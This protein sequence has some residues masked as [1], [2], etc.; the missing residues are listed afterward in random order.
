MSTAAFAQHHQHAVLAGDS[1]CRYTSTHRV[2]LTDGH[3]FQS[4][5]DRCKAALNKASASNH[6]CSREQWHEEQLAFTEVE[7]EWYARPMVQSA[8][9]ESINRTDLLNSL[10]VSGI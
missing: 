7:F 9:A 1:C 10:N 6:I 3:C 8:L 4:I 5:R 2:G